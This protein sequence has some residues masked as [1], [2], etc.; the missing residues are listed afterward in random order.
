MRMSLQGN[1]VPGS[2]SVLEFGDLEV[3]VQHR[4]ALGFCG[5]ED[6]VAQ[7]VHPQVSR[8]CRFGQ[9]GNCGS[10][11]CRSNWP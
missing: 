9:E 6:M 3:Y 10:P 1:T 5:S 4:V 11:P 8:K 2:S 7:V